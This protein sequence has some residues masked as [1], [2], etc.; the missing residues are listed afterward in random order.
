MYN[1]ILKW[2]KC[3]LYTNFLAMP[4]G[5]NQGGTHVAL[6]NFCMLKFTFIF[7]F[8][9]RTMFS[10]QCLTVYK[11]MLTIKLYGHQKIKFCS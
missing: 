4:L 8:K 6:Y 5:I 2:L 7:S 3:M 1:S 11:H 10:H 9:T